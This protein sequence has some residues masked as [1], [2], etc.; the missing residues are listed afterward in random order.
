MHN[1][2]FIWQLNYLS[3]QGLYGT[4]L[5]LSNSNPPFTIVLPLFLLLYKGYPSFEV[6]VSSI[7]DFGYFLVHLPSFK[8]VLHGPC[9]ICFFTNLYSSGSSCSSGISAD[10]KLSISST[11]SLLFS[12]INT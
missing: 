4:T 5:R 8:H 1:S 11:F 10:I 6:Y 2:T 7:K 12:H 9:N 3:S